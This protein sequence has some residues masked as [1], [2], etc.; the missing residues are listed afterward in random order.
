MSDDL[1]NVLP[2]LASP[3]TPLVAVPS[4]QLESKPWGGWATFGLGLAIFF[5][6]SAV[7]IIVMILY[8]VVMV[9]TGGVIEPESLKTDGLMLSLVTLSGVPVMYGMCILF[10]RMRKTIPWKEYLALRPISGKTAAIWIG[11]LLLLDALSCVW[12]SFFNYPV[13]EFMTKMYDSAGSV[14]LLCVAMIFAAPISE[15]F[16]FRGFFFIGFQRSKL[17]NIGAIVLTSFLWAII[18]ISQY[19]THTVV[20]IGLMG[21]LLGFARLR[22]RSIWPTLLM[23]ATHNLI[24]MAGVAYISRSPT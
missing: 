12:D 23:H 4:A 6:Y 3:T 13:P 19:E 21:I 16:L 11:A 15:E 18:H 24:A 9:A 5:A 7:Q 1:E 17:G 10:A 14:P 2:A 8:V 20:Q 22:T